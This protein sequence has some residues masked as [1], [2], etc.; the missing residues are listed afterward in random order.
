MASKETGN[1][2]EWTSEK[3]YH[4]RMSALRP[5]LLDFY[6]SNPNFI[7]PESRMKD[8]IQEV[9]AGLQDLS[10]SRPRD[11]LSWG[12]PVPDDETQTIYVWVDALINYLTKANYPFQI[13]GEEHARG[14]PADC[15]VI[16]KDIVRFH[17]IYWPALLLALD[18]PLPKRILTHAH[19]TLGKQKMS[20][21]TGMVVNPFFA[22]SRFG[23]DCMR[24]YLILDGGIKDDAAYD[25]KFIIDKYKKGL[26]GGL[27]NLVSRITRGKGWSVR[28]AVQEGNVPLTEELDQQFKLC[29]ERLP[30]SVAE[31]MDKLN[32]GDAL[33]KTM[34]VVYD[35]NAYLQQ[36]KPWDLKGPE[37]AT[38][39]KEVIY[40]TAESI[41][42]CG[43]LL[44]PFMPE[45]M[46][47]LLDLLDVAEN[48]RLFV[49]TPF[50]SDPHYGARRFS[51]AQ[52]SG[53]TL[54]PGV[55]SH[56]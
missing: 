1:E 52:Q 24:W 21:S 40:L 17:C 47:K 20:K 26:S 15:H 44:Q 9:E 22:I 25:N 28:E 13:P 48:A 7:V 42:I 14:W 43:I 34:N 32:P 11:R 33:A 50:A 45:K 18:L 53:E 27:G 41:R 5:R 31:D 8:V 23:V 51:L 55:A 37:N 46:Q 4:F 16:G 12:I 39:L 35:T 3:N 30:A 2:V 38:R 6:K 54:F 19:W 49:N 10:V 29:L 36:T 56:F